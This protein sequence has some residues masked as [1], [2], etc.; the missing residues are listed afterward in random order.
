MEFLK[1]RNLCWTKNQVLLSVLWSISSTDDQRYNTVKLMIVK[2]GFF[3]FHLA[4]LSS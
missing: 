2:K 1:L 3:G 4:F